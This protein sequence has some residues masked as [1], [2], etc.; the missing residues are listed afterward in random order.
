M[1]S[2]IFFIAACLIGCSGGPEPNPAPSEVVSGTVN[3][4]PA[5]STPTEPPAPEPDNHCV[6]VID[7]VNDCEVT[8]VYCYNQ[9][10]NLDIKCG[11]G[12]ILFPWEYIPDPPPPWVD[13]NSHRK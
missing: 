1:K 9:L 5:P 11:S 7:W 2:L 10:K 13:N 3:P 4:K 6:V 8:K 12:R